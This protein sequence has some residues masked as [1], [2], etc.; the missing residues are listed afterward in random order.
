MRLI[1]ETGEQL[2]IV[3]SR[4]AQSI[5]EEKGLDLVKISPSANPPVCKLMNYGKYLF[6]AAKKAKE[7][8]KNQKTVEIK[9]MLVLDQDLFNKTMQQSGG[10]KVE[11][12]IGFSPYF[13][14]EIIGGDPSDLYRVD[15]VIAESQP[16][17][18]PRLD[19]LFSWGANNNLRDAIR[20]TLQ[21]L[22]PKGTVIY[23]YFVK[24]I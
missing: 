16:N 17:I 19:E 9:D 4:E 10:K 13:K 22:N 18:G 8:K 20:N 12:G 1:G 11:I 6:E 15:V 5:A 3:S 2:G 21:V 14:G 24:T 7:A 23:T